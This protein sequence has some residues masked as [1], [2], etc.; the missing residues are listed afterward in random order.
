MHKMW[1]PTQAGIYR[2]NGAERAVGLIGEILLFQSSEQPSGSIP[3]GPWSLT[4]PDQQLGPPTPAQLKL[5]PWWAL[6]GTY[7]ADTGASEESAMLIGKVHERHGMLCLGGRLT[8][9]MSIT[10]SAPIQENL[11]DG[12]LWVPIAVVNEQDC[13]C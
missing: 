11:T 3:D 13:T 4:A 8:V 7:W 5:W 2:L 6:T 12:P 1:K 9:F 10:H